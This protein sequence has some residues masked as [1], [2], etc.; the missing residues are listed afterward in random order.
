MI[1]DSQ[2]FQ[3]AEMTFKVI[4][5][6]RQWHDSIENTLTLWYWN[7]VESSYFMGR[8]LLALVN[9]EVLLRSQ[10]QRS[11]SLGTKMKKNRCLRIYS[12]KVDWCIKPTANSAH[13]VKYISAAETYNVLD[14]F[15]FF[16]QN[17]FFCK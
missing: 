12:W 6:H 8:L 2:R 15:L 5:G 3:T 16:F 17:R 14:I 10:S 11:R 1:L 4:Q 13:D 9:G 7:A